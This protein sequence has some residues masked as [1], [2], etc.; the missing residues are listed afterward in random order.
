VIVVGGFNT[1]IDKV[2][3]TTRVAVGGTTRLQCVRAYPGGKGLHVAQACALLGAPVRLVGLIDAAHRPWFER[4]LR[5]RHVEFEG[6]EVDEPIRACYAVRDDDGIVTELLEPGPRV[7][8]AL[9]AD[10]CDRLLAAVAAGGRGGGAVA[11][12]SADTRVGSVLSASESARAKWDAAATA[13][14]AAGAAPAAT[15]ANRHVLVLSGSLPAGCAPATYAT[16]IARAAALNIPVILDASGD[17]LRHGIDAGPMMI[18]PNRAEA[19][20]LL[21]RLAPA[22]ELE[23]TPRAD[24]AERMLQRDPARAHE[25]APSP[26]AEPTR[27]GERTEEETREWARHTAFALSRRGV[28]RVIITLG[29][30]GAVAAWDGRIATIDVPP[31]SR[32]AAPHGVES[33]ARESRESSAGESIVGDSP[34]TASRVGSAS[35]AEASPVGSGDAFVGG[36]AVGLSRALSADDTLRLAAACGAANA[37][38]AEPGWF[39]ARDVTALLREVVVTW[40]LL[41]L[42]VFGQAE[43]AQQ[44]VRVEQGTMVLETYE[45]GPPNVN[46]P[47]DLFSAKVNYPYTLRDNLSDRHAPAR[48]R[49]LTLENE[50][51][52]CIVLPDLGGHLYTCID[53]TN[54]ASLFYANPSIKKAAIAYRG[55]WS[56]LGIEFNFPVSHNWMTVSPVDFRTV[57]RADGSASVWIGNID[58][59]YGG[60]WRVELT[61][62]PG[63]ARLEQRTTL[64]NRGARRH[65]FYWW[66]NAGV[67]VWDDSRLFYPM[68]FTASHG[69]THVDTWPVNAQGVDLSIVGN[70]HYG[71]VSQFSHGSREPFMAVYHP[72]T[73]AG[74]AHYSSPLD[75]PSKKVW[76]WGDDADGLDWRKALSDNDS[77]YVEVQAGL[78]RN[79]ETY[80]FLQPQESIAFTEYWL[81]L[82]DIDGVTRVT[83]DAV[84]FV[85]RPARAAEA[86]SRAADRSTLRIGVNVTRAL[87]GATLSVQCGDAFRANEVVSVS[88]ARPLTKTLALTNVPADARCR[89]DLIDAQRRTLVSHTEGVFDML[90]KSEITLGRQASYPT[91]APERG[92]EADVLRAGTRDE[93][94]GRLLSAWS[95]Y[96]AGLTRFPDSADLHKAAGRLAVH[97][98]RFD[99]ARRH[100]DATAAQVSNDAET[101]YYL[102][103]ALVALDRA[104]LARTH[105]DYAQQ[106][107]SFRAPARLALANL[108]GQ[109]GRFAD[110]LT[111]V[112]QAAA[113]S[114]DSIKAGWAEVALLRRAKR[115]TEAARRLRHWQELDPI[116]NALR[117]EAT[118]L[119]S[120]AGERSS[121]SAAAAASAAPRERTRS[122]AS[123]A[124]AALWTHLA[125]DPERLLEVAVDY[126]DL[127]LYDDAVAL[128]AR[129]W[130]P[131]RSRPCAAANAPAQP[132]AGA[133]GAARAA[134]A[135]DCEDVAE[136]AHS[137]PSRELASATSAA[138]NGLAG[139][140][141][142]SSSAPPAFT[143][144][145]AMPSP[146][147]Y[148]LVAYY[149]GYC[150]RKLGLSG[151]ADFEAAS[152]MPTAYVFPNR[153]ETLIVLRDALADRPE[154][155]TARFLLG[156]LYLSGGQV[157]EALREWETVR[158]Q[159]PRIPVLHRNIGLTRLHALRQAGEAAAV[160]REGL[161]VDPG[162]IE[163]YLA[164]DQALSVIGAPPADRAAALAR[165]PGASRPQADKP[166]EARETPGRAP[167]RPGEGAAIGAGAEPAVPATLVFKL[168]LAYAEAG[169]F[170]EAEAAFRGRFFPREEGGLNVREIYLEVRLLRARAASRAAHCD[171]ALTI[172]GTLTKP[173]PDLAFTADGL[174]P[175]VGTARFHYELGA[176]A[177]ACG[178]QE[179]ATTHWKQVASAKSGSPFLNIYY[180]YAAAQRLGDF[181][182]GAGGESRDKAEWTPRL[183][184]ALAD[185]QALLDAGSANNVSAVRVARGGL[186]RALGKED[187]ARE[188]LTEA[189][190][191]PDR[192]LSHHLARLA[193]EDAGR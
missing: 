8:E 1:A 81:P 66:T 158:K 176:I 112:Q 31:A 108:A 42:F 53:K 14:T 4:T 104:D 37:C 155:T 182:G 95:A 163:V 12:A 101:H 54:G 183:Q 120:G 22:S 2:A 170:D 114:P 193:R 126:I 121:S 71:P 133:P 173:R 91:P 164:L 161:D 169:R 83:P 107:Q 188:Q 134:K 148:P 40:C 68:T 27:E 113:E 190:R 98:K 87:A 5:A 125:A 32:V 109:A 61:L 117:V 167:A 60:E 184:Q 84:L 103:L 67:Q 17:A 102:G 179:S 7:S 86:T 47:F 154:D 29:E 137:A 65:R 51:L 118:R 135:K 41:L 93:L 25:T 77:A 140:A 130:T 92:T 80:A 191:A 78:F 62:R 63:E 149:R 44:A 142:V 97:L 105:F 59:V 166:S 168:A 189:L 58:R 145:P 23:R 52:R 39:D 34:A 119:A 192:Q 131:A 99:A 21:E 116:N 160:L 74:V 85:E 49:T 11:G 55:A 33:H 20:E 174:D 143:T 90:S 153:P 26:S 28:P 123:N 35:A 94:D 43:G 89:V 128:L 129:E 6:V 96:D 187:E 127:G 19:S 48:W 180:A 141:D 144:E 106:F 138:A 70:H 122:A 13:A 185:S 115:T 15:P 72:R 38:T 45:E 139:T 100:L 75:L 76:S 146:A 132:K 147:S 64:Y 177:A 50:Y 151:R 186:L 57:T 150:R 171:E 10:W 165:F 111:L 36:L 30:A 136:G 9:V 110:A 16:V 156:S 69:F 18:K 82:R 46:P 175:F 56:A 88:P 152:R 73:H 181:S 124:D 79:Q 172:V 157:D 159:N 24:V 178:R 3:R 162:N